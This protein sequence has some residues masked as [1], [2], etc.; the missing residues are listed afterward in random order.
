MPRMSYQYGTSPRKYEP[1]YTPRKT[2]KRATKKIDTN[3]KYAKSE[4]KKSDAKKRIEKQ[5]KEKSK[6]RKNKTLQVVFVLIVF[7][8]LLAVSYREISIMEMFNQKKDLENQLA[9]I[10]K[11]NGQIEKSIREEESKLDWNDIQ[12]IAKQ[13]LGMQI[14][15]AIS[16][17]LE[18]SDNV[19]TKNTFIK[20]EQSSLLEKIVEYFINK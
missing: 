10:E 12:T 19:E 17:D 20:E 7:G 15:P 2:T 3:K 18:K 8:M 14:K 5:R 4:P 6:E 11:E 9:T 1:E 13:E 16:V